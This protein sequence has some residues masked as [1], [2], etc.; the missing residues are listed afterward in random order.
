MGLIQAG[1]AICNYNNHGPIIGS[2][3]GWDLYIGDK[4]NQSANSAARFPTAYNNP[5]FLNHNQ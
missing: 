5:N 1:Q 2:I 3:N 4:S